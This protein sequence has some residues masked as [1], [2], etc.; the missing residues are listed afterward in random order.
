MLALACLR[1]VVSGLP[2]TARIL[3]RRS[4]GASGLK[5]PL[6]LLIA[7]SGQSKADDDD[8]RT[9]DI[10]SSQK[11]RASRD[12]VIASRSISAFRE[13]ALS[14][15]RFC[16]RG[17]AAAVVPHSARRHL[18]SRD[19]KPLAASLVLQRIGQGSR[20]T[21][22]PELWTPSWPRWKSAARKNAGDLA[23]AIRLGRLSAGALQRLRGDSARL[24]P[25]PIPRRTP[26]PVRIHA[27]VA[28][29]S[30]AFLDCRAG[31]GRAMRP[32][33]HDGHP[34]ARRPP[35]AAGRGAQEV[36]ARQPGCRHETH[37]PGARRI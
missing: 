21:K 14:A 26:G 31:K 12:A 7:E 32:R 18:V 5:Q 24:Q 6:I 8:P 10:K 11:P 30:R 37:R 1:L 17:N 15:T 33:E 16:R 34:W 35:D 29:D 9:P 25:S 23:A 2:P 13:T 22:P 4:S 19:E 20:A 27:W 36:D 3:T 28:P